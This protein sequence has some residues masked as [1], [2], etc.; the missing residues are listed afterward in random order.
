MDA[1]F[2]GLRYLQQDGGVLHQKSDE[3]PQKH[4]NSNNI[5][6][7]TY[8]VSIR[9]QGIDGHPYIVLN[10]KE[11]HLSE[12]DYLPDSSSQ[13]LRPA[14]IS[15]EHLFPKNPLEASIRSTNKTQYLNSG[16]GFKD[17]AVKQSTLLNF[18]KHPELLK[19]YDPNEHRLN[20]EN[21]KMSNN[22]CKLTADEDPK[23]NHKLSGSFY[24]GISTTYSSLKSLDTPKY[25]DKEASLNLTTKQE[26]QS[27]LSSVNKSILSSPGDTSTSE[28]F[29]SSNG[30][31]SSNRSIAYVESKKSRPDVLQFR[32][33]NS[34][35]AIEGS[36]SRRSSGS[37][38]ATSQSFQK[39]LTDE[40]EDSLYA[41]NVNRHENRRYIPFVP[42]TGRDIDTGCILGVD[43][44]IEKFDR[45]I[46]MQRRGRS[47]KRNKI[48][49]EDRKR[50]RSVDSAYPFGLH[51]NSEYLN[52]YSK[53]L[54]KSNEHLLKPSKICPQKTHTQYYKMSFKRQNTTG[55]LVSQP[56]LSDNT[57]S[58]SYGSL[59]HQKEINY[60][61]DEPDSVSYISSTLPNRSKKDEDVKMIKSTLQLK[62]CM[63]SPP[64]EGLRK[65]AATMHG[66]CRV[67]QATPDLL[68]GQQQ[69]AQQTNE[70][71]AKQILFNYLKEGSP[72]NDDAT[73]RKVNL[74]F[75]KIQ[76]LK[77][78][79]ASTVQDPS[80]DIKVLQEQKNELER[81][82][83][84]MQERLD[85]E[86]KNRKSNKEESKVKANMNDIQDQLEK[87]ME[88]NVVL[89]KRLGESEKELRKHLEEL[90]ELK[91][92]QEQYQTEIRDLQEQ[93]SEMHDEL[94]N[95]KSS[96]DDEEREAFVEELMQMKQRFQE[97]LLVKEEQ[98][99][100]L[101]KRER[102]LTALKGALKEE[103]STHDQE[104][105]KLKEQYD[106]ELKKI[107]DNLNEEVKNSSDIANQ[108]NE[109]SQLKAVFENKV[110][111]LLQENEELKR[112]IEN[113]E[114]KIAGL[115]QEI[116]DFSEENERLKDKLSRSEKEK[117]HLTITLQNAKD[118]EKETLQFAR[119]LENQ[120][121]DT[122]RS[123]SRVSHEHQQLT[124]RLKEEANQ[125]EQLRNLKNE[126]ENER[127]QLDKTI[128]KLQKEISVN[129]EFSRMSTVELQKQFDEYKDKHRRESAEMQRQ[130]KDKNLE[131]ESACQT[132]KKLQ[133]E[134]RHLEENLQDHQRAQD[135]ALTKNHLLQQTI[136][137]LQYELDAKTHVKDDRIRQIKS[138]EDKI[139]Q[140]EMEL[141]EEKN[142]SDLLLERVTRCREQIEQTRSELFQERATKQDLECDKISLDR[143]NKDLKSRIVH[144]ENSHRS[145]KE[146]LVAQMETRIAELEERLEYEERD[147]AS[148][149]LNNRRLERKVKELMMQVDDEHL[150][151]TDQKD[152]LSLRL[153]SMKRQV[154]EAE[155]EIDRLESAKKKLQRDLEEQTDLN[156]QLQA[157]LTATKKELSR[158]KSS[159][160]RMVNDLEDDDDDDLST[161]GESLYDGPSVYT[162]SR[163]DGI[164]A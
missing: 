68:K 16:N 61:T 123:L 35:G 27:R 63:S 135:E 52:E 80:A 105:D 109:A 48:N 28:S 121:E 82:V 95:A 107:R 17:G 67:A 9:V 70:E 148:L 104:I 103:V 12:N 24:K 85:E 40:Q 64:R 31:P 5:K 56:S 98:E 37:S 71:T 102:E 79:A 65:S 50:S 75:E 144:L 49:P 152:Q 127:W 90:F 131:V 2:D 145:N 158:R 132:I 89:R 81:K 36:R 69:V 146:G 106:K 137:D 140:L 100:L 164:R 29:S 122:K 92:E 124:E 18:Q 74:V 4:R 77:S 97:I 76:T 59:Q 72:D 110:K 3:R 129:V 108:K 47:A 30:S 115:R 26:V 149:Q 154:E 93:L 34:A 8:G 96:V 60:R 101:R 66:S 87:S 155:E 134:V 157:Q 78:R 14:V 151:L 1:R 54:G 57:Q 141:D 159:P 91:M 120:L 41:E 86:M 139:S 23:K 138:M 38:T 39:F 83:S 13:S 42:G 44:L 22:Q 46:S 126:M 20:D 162:F 33:Q 94:D 130:I 161:D 88:E 117:Q 143:Q 116:N 125:K 58:K 119:K 112:K 62:D 128:E 111:V 25:E 51:S 133:D 84:S 15:S 156:D 32:R 10:N 55:S 114:D 150:T 153:K 21:F 73:K 147:R 11:G 99:D 142:N 6:E 19:P 7:G 163:D 118:Q 43:E 136:K 160:S 45:N 53:S 113:L